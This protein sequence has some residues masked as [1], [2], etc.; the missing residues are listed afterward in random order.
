MLSRRWCRRAPSHKFSRPVNWKGLFDVP[1]TV[2]AQRAR[3]VLSSLRHQANIIRE[4]N[5]SE[6][7]RRQ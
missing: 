4:G 7:D 3:Q 2:V 5:G 1:M 6:P